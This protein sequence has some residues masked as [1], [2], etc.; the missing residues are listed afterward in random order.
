MDST[1]KPELHVSPKT[2]M[3]Q[4]FATGRWNANNAQ[5]AATHASTHEMLVPLGLMNKN[6]G[7]SKVA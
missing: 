2:R 6:V 7:K 1:E 3:E 4:I 5:M